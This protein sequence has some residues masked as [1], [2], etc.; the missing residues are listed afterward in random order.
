MTRLPGLELLPFTFGDDSEGIE[1]E[2]ETGSA[3]EEEIGV[4]VEDG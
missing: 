4:K 1:A 3:E 2:A